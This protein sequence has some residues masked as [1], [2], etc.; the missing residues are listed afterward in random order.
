MVQ[1]VD[2]DSKLYRW[3]AIKS[4]QIKSNLFVTKKE[5]NATQ[6]KQNKCL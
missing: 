6:R 1:C 2:I 3:I 4:N 5:Q